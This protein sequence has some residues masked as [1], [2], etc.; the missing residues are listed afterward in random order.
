M[1][2]KEDREQLVT[3][4]GAEAKWILSIMLEQRD[5]PSIEGQFHE[6]ITNGLGM[7]LYQINANYLS[8]SDSVQL[9]H[10]AYAEWRRG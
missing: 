8:P 7:A 1:K 3:L 6:A 10:E 4:T 2:I 5:N 9:R